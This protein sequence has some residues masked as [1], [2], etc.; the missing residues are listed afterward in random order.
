MPR[1]QKIVPIQPPLLATEQLLMLASTPGDVV[2]S[3]VDPSYVTLT[4]ITDRPVGFMLVVV[5]SSYMKIA[6]L[7]WGKLFAGIVKQLK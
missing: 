1:Q 7:P 6:A 5:P 4:N 3:N 2:M